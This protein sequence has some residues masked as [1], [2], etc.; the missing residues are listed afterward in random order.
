MTLLE[1]D[2]RAAFDRMFLKF[3]L[4]HRGAS[5]A[6]AQSERLYG[7]F[8]AAIRVARSIESD[9]GC[10]DGQP[11]SSRSGPVN[12]ADRGPRESGQAILRP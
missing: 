2:C 11:S 5:V 1:A 12:R 9:P 3:M 10:P 6:M 4:T 8:G 7:Q